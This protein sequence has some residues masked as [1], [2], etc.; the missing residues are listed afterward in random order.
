LPDPIGAPA[1]PTSR[2]ERTRTLRRE[3]ERLEPG[4]RVLAE[5]VL[6][7]SSRIDLVATDG[8]RRVVA[9]T[10]A[11]PGDGSRA[12]TTALAHRSWLTDHVPDWLK[13]ASDLAI[14]ATAAV[15]TLLIATDFEPELLA[16][17]AVLPAGWVEL[18]ELVEIARG[19]QVHSELVPH[20]V[21]RRNDADLPAR[22]VGQHGSAA[23]PRFRTGLTPRE[24]GLSDEEIAQFD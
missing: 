23:L 17:V 20:P 21:P 12:L 4:V 5:G 6:A 15:R 22:V 2:T 14:D 8:R 19:D 13:L 1:P 7:Q 11:E 16:A 18:V 3:L 10:F 9:A 24:L